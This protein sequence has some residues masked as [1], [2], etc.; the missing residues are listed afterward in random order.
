MGARLFIQSIDGRRVEEELAYPFDQSRLLIGRTGAADVRLPH[1]TVSERHASLERSGDHFRLTDHGSTNGTRVG[2]EKLVPHRAKRLRD[3]DLV[4]IGVYVLAYHDEVMVTEPLTADRTAELA[5]RL[6]REQQHMLSSQT[7]PPRLVVLGGPRTGERLDLPPPPSRVQIGRGEHCQL[8]L[9]DPEAMDEEV[10]LVRDLDG[11]LARALY[12]SR[13]VKIGSRTY[14]EHRLKDGDE[15]LVGGT[16]L[17]FEEPAESALGVLVD[18]EDEPLRQRSVRTT[19]PVEAP[20]SADSAAANTSAEGKSETPA[21]S[22]DSPKPKVDRDSLVA[23]LLIYGLASAILALSI[24]GL[25]LLLQ[26]E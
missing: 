24:A 6:L 17:L 2:G 1:R 15:V 4:E 26:A 8:S 21:P 9:P 13:P 19:V 16:V 7:D 12:P 23:D 3:G 11:V 20:A 14:Q 10:E 22:A 5:R 18:E 25:F